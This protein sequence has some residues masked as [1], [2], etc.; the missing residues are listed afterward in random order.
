MSRKEIFEVFEKYGAKEVLNA[1]ATNGYAV[2]LM[3]DYI[4][5][6]EDVIIFFCQTYEEQEEVLFDLAKE[7]NEVLFK[8]PR[9]QGLINTIAIKQLSEITFETPKMG[10]PE[11]KDQIIKRKDSEGVGC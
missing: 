5:S 6:L 1:Y 2:E 4:E 3:E 7:G 8:V 10:L 9:I 11:I